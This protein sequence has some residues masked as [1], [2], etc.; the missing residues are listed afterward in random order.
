MKKILLIVMLLCFACSS[1]SW[2]GLVK[3]DQTLPAAPR[4]DS[5]TPFFAEQSA[6]YSVD[7][8][9]PAIKK[10]VE[11]TVLD[12]LKQKF[13]ELKKSPRAFWKSLNK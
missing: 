12:I 3:K 5:S 2:L 4:T 9:T 10:L 8:L 11:T 13:Q 1:C 7:A 6:N